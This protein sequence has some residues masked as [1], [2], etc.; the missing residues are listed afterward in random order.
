[1][2]SV[3][4]TE[5]WLSA[6]VETEI[7]VGA[8]VSVVVLSVM[9]VLVSEVLELLELSSYSPQEMMVRLKHEIKKMFVNFF[10]F[11]PL[12]NNYISTI[13]DEVT[14]PNLLAM[15]SSWFTESD[16]DC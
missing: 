15:S 6:V 3:I 16:S 1:M 8:V 4:D 10:I 2:L 14:I 13:K 5:L 12:K 9:V 11:V 7:T